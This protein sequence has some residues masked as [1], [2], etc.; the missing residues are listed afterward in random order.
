MKKHPEAADSNPKIDRPSPADTPAK[1]AHPFP[2]VGIGASAGGLEALEQ[3]LRH[4]TENCGI[5]FVIVQHLDPTHKGIMPELLQRVTAMEVFQ[6]RD[7]MRVKPSCVY[8]IPPNKDMSILHG[9]LH[10]FDPAATRGLR[11]PIDFFFQS[12]AAD[13][14]E[15]SIGVILSGM[16][17][18][19]TQG[20][21]AIK[22]NG[23][24]AFVQD[25]TS[26]RF[27]SMPKS[28]INAGLADI[29]APVE[30]LPGKIIDFLRHALA[31][32]RGEARLEKKD[33]SAL[34]KVLILLRAKTGNDFS[35]YKKNTIYRRI[36]RRMGIHQ[37]DQIGSYVRYLQD[38][39][40]EIELLF[41]ELLIGVTS[42][43]RDPEAWTGPGSGYPAAPGE[44]PCRR[45]PARLV[46]RLF[47]RRGSVFAG[48]RLQRSARTGQTGGTFH[49]ADICH[50]SGPGCH[51]L[52]PPRG[53]SG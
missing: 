53:L 44:L 2:I 13:R 20:L 33:Q 15:G 46:N 29:V 40:Q 31:I 11:L 18:D 27:D 42:F 49:H 30:E 14:H 25:P 24:I 43:F 48:D 4:V 16:G 26:A 50:R 47:N 17:S 21:R 1:K 10:L 3:F 45:M 9:V 52:C 34:E 28:A 38:N 19:G 8:V 5:A 36:E 12:L 32:T 37:I 6:V 22:E 41:K 51:R 7:R 23:G 39:P 35:L